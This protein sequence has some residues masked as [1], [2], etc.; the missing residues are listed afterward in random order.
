MRKVTKYVFGG[1]GAALREAA[2]FGDV[3]A[4]VGQFFADAVNLVVEAL[5]GSG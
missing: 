4:D 1:Y 3:V 5:D 2:E